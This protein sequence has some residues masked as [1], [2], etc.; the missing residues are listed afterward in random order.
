MKRPPVTLVPR[1]ISHDTVEACKTLLTRAE[2]G[3]L[4]GLAWTAMYENRTYDDGTAG[5]AYDNPNWTC[6]MLMSLI[7]RLLRK[8]NP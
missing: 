2:Q 7:F 3:E 6:A 4:I 5:E 8:I 1:T